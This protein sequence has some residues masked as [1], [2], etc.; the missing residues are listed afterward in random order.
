MG[1]PSMARMN[2]RRHPL[3][4]V[5][6]LEDRHVL[7]QV[8]LAHPAERPQ[9]V[10]QPRPQPLLRVVV[11]LAHPVPVVVPRPLPRGVADRRPR[12]ARSRPAGRTRRHSSVLTRRRRLGSPR[13]PPGSAS[14]RRRA[15]RPTAG[16]APLSRPDHPADRRP[17]VVPGAV[18]AGACWPAAAAGRR[19]SGC[20]MPFFPRVLVHLVGLD[21]RVVQPALVPV[22]PGRVL[23]PVPQPSNSLRSQP[24]S[25]A[26]WAVGTP[27]AKP[28][29]ISTSSAGRRW[30]PCR[31]VPVKALKT[32][33][34]AGSGSRGP[35]RGGGGGRPG[36]RGPAPGAGQAVGVEPVRGAWRSRRPRPSG[37]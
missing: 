6:P 31:A 17:V 15:A 18:A 35:G 36:R 14:R 25:R 16:P 22:P 1:T 13:A 12:R 11:D 2:S 29:R 3:D 20:G 5:A 9:E 21:H 24:S 30:V 33:R 32:R 8:L 19:G 27:W 26:S 34:Q 4:V 7:V 10:P 37:R 23:E 28:R